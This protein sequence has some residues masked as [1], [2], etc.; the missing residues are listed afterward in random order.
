MR[1]A[2]HPRMRACGWSG[3]TPFGGGTGL[4]RGRTGT[5]LG[6]IGGLAQIG[7]RRPSSSYKQAMPITEQSPALAPAAVAA[8][9]GTGGLLV[10]FGF[11]RGDARIRKRIAAFQ[12]DGWEVLGFTFH[13]LRDRID[14]SVFWENVEMG[15]TENRRYVKRVFTL[16]RSLL[17]LWNH[18]DRLRAARIL[19]AVNADNGLLALAAR[20]FSR[21]RSWCLP[22]VLEMAD[23]QPAMLG[24]GMG[25]QVMRWAERLVLRR[26]ALL[27]TTSPG[28]ITNY[29]LPVQEYQGEVFFLENKVYPSSGMGA[30]KPGAAGDGAFPEKPGAGLGNNGGAIRIHRQP[31]HPVR[32]GKPWVIG[33]FGAFRC[34]RSLELIHGLAA[35]FP[36]DVH[37][38]LRGYAS[39][40]E[41]TELERLMGGISNVEFGG[42]YDY[43][44]DLPGMYDRVDF[45]WAFDFTDSGGNSA[46]LLPNRIYEGGL[47]GCPVFAAA[48]TETGRWAIAHEAGWTFDEPIHEKLAE[49]FRT[50]T[51]DNWLEC[52]ER[53][54]ELPREVTCGEADYEK[55]SGVFHQL[56][57][58]LFRPPALG[59]PE[60]TGPAGGGPQSGKNGGFVEETR[61][62]RSSRGSD[63]TG[64]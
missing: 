52:R 39:G 22:L 19:Y 9:D 40:A 37:F 50:V 31:G 26:T 16:A 55:L 25:P 24:R 27:V 3:Y 61:G 33:Y 30:G 2:D 35:R 46:W 64:G 59:S 28:F 49:F 51:L 60:D 14:P 13:R 4:C 45:N 36:E 38:Y 41:A 7:C 15:I 56:A 58:F 54:L 57:G 43:P 63:P 23:V 5:D 21:S 44:A 12:A 34:R 8:V 6:W 32:G 1:H 42:A 11:E 48:D 10:F 17:I 47:F 62:S 53:C 20:W 29:F 18:R